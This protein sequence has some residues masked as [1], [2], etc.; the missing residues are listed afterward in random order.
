MV[1]NSL[2]V[3]LGRSVFPWLPFNSITEVRPSM[4]SFLPLYFIYKLTLSHFKH[5]FPSILQFLAIEHPLL[6][7]EYA[8]P[9]VLLDCACLPPPTASNTGYVAQRGNAICNKGALR[10]ETSFLLM[11]MEDVGGIGAVW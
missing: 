5:M 10:F 9:K 1:F 11:I 7:G 4:S 6:I 2:G 3:N 8:R